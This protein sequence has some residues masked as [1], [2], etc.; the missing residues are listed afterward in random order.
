MARVTENEVA[1][2][3]LRIAVTKRGDICTLDD[4]RAEVPNHISLS[5]D[6]LKDS[7]TRIGEPMWHQQIRNLQSHHDVDENFIHDGFVLFAQLLVVLAL[8]ESSPASV[9]LPR[10]R[11]A[12][13]IHLLDFHI[14]LL[15]DCHELLL[16]L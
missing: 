8:P 14:P 2:A 1:L 9:F 13:F 5:K 4:A 7:D 11:S 6:D 12:Q 10:E 3:V 16:Q 15:C